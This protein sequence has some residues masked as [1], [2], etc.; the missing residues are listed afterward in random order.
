MNETVAATKIVD[1]IQSKYL[2]FVTRLPGTLPSLRKKN[3]AM[4]PTP[5]MGKLIQKIHVQE[6]F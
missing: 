5:I 6:I 1:P 2:I 3:T 4:A